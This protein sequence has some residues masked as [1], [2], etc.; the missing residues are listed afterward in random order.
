MSWIYS[1]NKMLIDYKK[2]LKHDDVKYYKEGVKI[3]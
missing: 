2:K 1:V 3:T